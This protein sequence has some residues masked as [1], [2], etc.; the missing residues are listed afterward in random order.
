M[1]ATVLVADQV[2][3]PA[4]RTPF[5][6]RRYLR[7]AARPGATTPAWADFV[8]R[9]WRAWSAERPAGE[10]VAAWRA[11][12]ARVL[13]VLAALGLTATVVRTDRSVPL[14]RHDARLAGLVVVHPAGT[15]ADPAH[16][17]PGG[18]EHACR[19][20]MAAMYGFT[21]ADGLPTDL[22]GFCGQAA[23][24]KRPPWAD[25]A[26]TWLDRAGDPVL[27]VEAYPGAYDPTAI[28]DDLDG[29]PL[30][31][32]GPHPGF[33]NG[34]TLLLLRGDPHALPLRADEPEPGLDVGEATELLSRLVRAHDV[35]ARALRGSLTRPT[36]SSL[37]GLVGVVLAADEPD[38]ALCWAAD[39]L[40]DLTVAGLLDRDTA[41]TIIARTLRRL[42]RDDAEGGRI[43]ADAEGGA[44]RRALDQAAPQ[45]R[46]A[47]GDDWSA[48]VFAATAADALGLLDVPGLAET[49]EWS[50][51]VE[52]AAVYG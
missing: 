22:R 52:M 30:L 43:V 31:V 45:V 24:Y 1:T 44:I 33:R 10:T 11:V 51:A 23:R 37:A 46:A 48:R 12:R 8:D 50:L 9:A 49:V 13:G 19:A 25:H 2:R 17:E 21:P 47:L 35:A 27:S 39:R 41:G 28:V 40:A 15:P 18:V 3:S 4:S 38:R 7:D 14:A 16:A 36:S 29:L 42:G 5:E 32:D 34:S 6:F 26:R 20:H